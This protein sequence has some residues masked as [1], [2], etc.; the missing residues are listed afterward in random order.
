MGRDLPRAWDAYYT[1]EHM[2][3]SL[4]RAAASRMGMSRLLSVLF[5]FST[6][7]QVEGVHPLQGGVFR[8]KYRRDRRSTLSIEPVWSSIPA[9]ISLGDRVGSTHA[10]PGTGS[11]LI[12]CANA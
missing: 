11:G 6:C 9:E 4:R 1:P 12:V 3:E 8:F 10:S 7:F 5:F 2:D